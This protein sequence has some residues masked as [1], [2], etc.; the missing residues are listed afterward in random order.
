M[1]E[2]QDKVLRAHAE[3]E[4]LRSRT[5]RQSEQ[6]RRFA[7]SSFAKDLLDVADNMDRA[8]AALPAP[9]REAAE[10]GE[11]PAG[12]EGAAATL[13][14]LAVGLS[15]TAKALAKALG[16]HGVVRFEPSV[17]DA[18]DPHSHHALFQLPAQPGQE[19]GAVAAVTKAGYRLHDRVLRPAEVGVVA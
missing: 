15:M 11:A 5:A 16:K 8:L 9:V 3:M 4:N 1:A 12:A 2:Y 17:G 18:L 6:E 19:K 10:A 14:Q 13:H 7:V